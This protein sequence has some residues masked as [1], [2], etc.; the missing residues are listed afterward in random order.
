MITQEQLK[1][2]LSYDPETGQFIWIRRR[3]G[4]QFGYFLG[5][6]QPHGYR[7]ICLDGK[8]YYA[9]RLA[10]LY[11]YGVFPESELDHVNGDKSDNTINNLR[12]ATSCANKCNSSLRSDNTSG[13]K[14]V[15]WNQD[16]QKWLAQIH[17][18]G[19]SYFIGVF[20]DKLEAA[21]AYD[22]EARKRFGAFA[23]CNGV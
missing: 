1:K 13:F 4:R 20:V 12:E 7:K 17:Q 16:C 19:K 9:H 14:G 23:K 18:A 2:E 8:K 6:L 15:T 3:Q 10:W 22:T 5:A 11:V 21:R